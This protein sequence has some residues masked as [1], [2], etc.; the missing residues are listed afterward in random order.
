MIMC[1]N[2]GVSVR[3]VVCLSVYVFVSTGTGVHVYHTTTHHSPPIT[4]GADNVVIDK[5][6]CRMY[7]FLIKIINVTP[8]SQT[9][10]FFSFLM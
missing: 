3:G 1:V 10:Y 6:S 4:S 7:Q 5:V 2:V 8:D 9:I